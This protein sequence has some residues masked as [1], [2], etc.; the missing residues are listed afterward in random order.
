MVDSF[1]VCVTFVEQAKTPA[2]VEAVEEEVAAE[3]PPPPA[4]VA[5]AKAAPV[6]A[7]KPPEPAPVAAAAPK[8]AAAKT[9]AKAAA[10]AP[11]AAAPAAKSA[12]GQWPAK[13]PPFE[14]PQE[15][16]CVGVFFFCVFDPFFSRD[17]LVLPKCLGN[18]AL[19][20]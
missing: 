16:C 7:S 8:K 9:P 10:A 4:P 13:M 3:P 17:G 1:A 2:A 12:S 18:S 15:V 19:W 6:A 20:K 14:L 11:A 5:K